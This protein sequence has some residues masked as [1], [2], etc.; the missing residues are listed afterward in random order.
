MNTDFA[1]LSDQQPGTIVTLLRASYAQLLKLDPRWE[2]EEEKWEEYDRQVFVHPKTVGAC[3]FLTR[4]EG[5]IV[6][7]GSWDPRQKPEY[8]IIGHNC[9]LPEFQGNGLGKQ[10]IQEILGRFQ[11]LGIKIAKAST[12]D[13]FFFI[14]A[15]RMYVACGFLEVRRI[16]WM[17]DPNQKMIEY[18]KDL[19]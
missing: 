5:H 19:S 8:G 16:P 10:Q 4:L 7:F 13:H 17:G 2:S 12:N 3:V 18:E 11:M 15:Q 14:P 6:G 1:T 9:I